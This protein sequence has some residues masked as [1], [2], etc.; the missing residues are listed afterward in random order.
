MQQEIS[1]LGQQAIE[2]LKS[3]AS[4]A[5]KAKKVFSTL[6]QKHKTHIGSAVSIQQTAR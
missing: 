5:E 2:H 4:S 6:S 1:Q 3:V